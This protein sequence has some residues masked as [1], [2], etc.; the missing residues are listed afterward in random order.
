MATPLQEY[1]EMI[2]II[3]ENRKIL[4]KGSC[5]QNFDPE[6]NIP[7]ALAPTGFCPSCEQEALEEL[8][9]RLM[10]DTLGSRKFIRKSPISACICT[11]ICDCQNPNP[12]KG[13]GLGSNECPVHNILLPRPHP[14]CR[15]DKYWFEN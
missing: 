10:E 1:L 4:C 3:R 15:A 13:V 12:E 7:S 14:E 5:R 9:D 6:A 8:A 2:P 11:R